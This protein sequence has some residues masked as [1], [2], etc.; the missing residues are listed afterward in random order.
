MLNRLER[1]LR[2]HVKRAIVATVPR[3]RPLARLEDLQQR[4]R[5]VGTGPRLSRL[6]FVDKVHGV[7]STRVR[8]FGDDLGHEKRINPVQ[9]KNSVFH[10]L[11]K[12]VPWT[13]F[14]RLV[15]AHGADK[16]V[17][18]LSTRSQFVALLYGQ[19]AGAIS[20]R[21]IAGGLESHSAIMSAQS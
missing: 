20:L 1:D 15:D 8:A 18:R 4:R 14:E 2:L 9:H 13:A 7:D 3:R 12:R 16:H 10:D 11:L 5:M 6:N 19:L 21:E 17:R